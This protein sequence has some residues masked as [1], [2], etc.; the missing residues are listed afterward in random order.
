M[1]KFK[2]EGMKE[3]ERSFKK[4]GQVPQKCVT[5]AARKGMNIALRSSQKNAP[6]DTGALKGGMK[7]IGEKARVKAKKVY[8]VVFDRKKNNI[9]QKQ[10]KEGQVTG[11]YPS[12]Q[13]Y[14]FFAKNGRYIPGVH[15]MKRAMEENSGTI[16]RKIVSEVSKNIDKALGGK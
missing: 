6:E 8:Q 4:L 7:L 13:E 14:G 10:N 5:P 3:L 16:T 12:S 1:A 15:F 9:F 2:I 11:Y